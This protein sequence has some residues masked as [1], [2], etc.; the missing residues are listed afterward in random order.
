MSKA[1]FVPAASINLV[2]LALALTV[3][4]ATMAA[5]ASSALANGHSSSCSGTAN[6][7]SLINI[8]N[9]DTDITLEGNSVLSDIELVSIENLAVIVAKNN[10]ACNQLITVLSVDCSKAVATGILA[11][12][13]ISVKDIDVTI[14][15][16][17][18]PYHH[19][20]WG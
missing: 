19:H 11:V 7:T 16:G 5:M 6:C 17:L 14:L 3:V 9:N 4:M 18:F 15:N 2:R 1:R 13:P 8:D 10:I 20:I 12:V